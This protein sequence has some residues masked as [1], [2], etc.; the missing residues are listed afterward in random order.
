MPRE[1]TKREAFERALADF[2]EVAILVVCT[3]AVAVPS[4]TWRLCEPPDKT[5]FPAVVLKYGLDMAKPI[6]DL[7]ITDEGIRATLSFSNEP[8]KTFVPWDAVA[9]I[10]G[11]GER[12]R[13][14]PQL[15]SV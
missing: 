6:P 9:G 15:R 13:Q 1:M 3:P 11:V 14:R 5:P 2:Y 10:E 4:D 12:P 7:E 8:I